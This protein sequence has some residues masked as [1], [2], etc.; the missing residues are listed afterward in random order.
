MGRKALAIEVDVAN[1]QE[2]QRMADIALRELGSVDILINCAGGPKLTHTLFHESTE[3][4]WDRLVNVNLKGTRNC[5][6]SIINHMI[7]RRR[8]KIVN[9]S[10]LAGLLGNIGSVDY[11][12]AK[13]GILGFTMALAKEV[14]GYGINVNC[15][16]PG[17]I[18]TRGMQTL[19]ERIKQN[20]KLTGMGRLGKP[21]EVASL[22]AFLVS[23]EAS[24]ITG[25]NYP[26]CGLKNLGVGF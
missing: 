18:I 16:S 9:I 7:E 14:A 1:S 2:T 20:E 12:A 5:T 13:A 4:D 11:S 17:A 22:V 3:E 19:P 26:I 25:Q 23:E 6:R 8:G 15:V 10:S 21:E 24:F